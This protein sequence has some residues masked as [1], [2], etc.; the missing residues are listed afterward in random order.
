M[1]VNLFT[2]VCALMASS[3]YAQYAAWPA[4]S[5][6]PFF[7]ALFG[8]ASKPV[9][10]LPSGAGLQAPSIPLQAPTF[11]LAYPFAQPFQYA[12]AAAPPAV[13]SP[14]AFVPF[15]KRKH[16][17]APSAHAPPAKKG[18]FFIENAVPL[19]KTSLFEKRK[20]WKAI[21]SLEKEFNL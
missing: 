21:K 2:L 4:T 19:V 15:S 11:P 8:L 13:F 16:R 1:K 7:E 12:V 3:I 6:S 5:Y 10:A 20:P 9:A 18:K 14:P 17:R